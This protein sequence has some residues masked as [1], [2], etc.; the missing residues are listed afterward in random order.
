[1]IMRITTALLACGLLWACQ[2]EPDTLRIVGQ[3][4]SDRIELTAESSEPI[5]VRRVIEGQLVMVGEPLVEQNTDRALAR[6]A[7]AEALLDQAQARLDEL[8]RGPRKEQILAAQAS[9]DGSVLELEYRLV[10]LDR[11]EALLSKALASAENRDSARSA[12]DSAA[13]RLEVNKARLQELLTGTTVEELEQARAVVGQSQARLR[14][15]QI[16][17]ERS[18]TVAPVAGVVDS[19]L[20]EAGER[21]VPG[22]PIAIMLSGTTTLRPGLYSRGCPGRSCAWRQDQGLCR[23]PGRTHR[24]TGSLGFERGV[25]HTLFR[26][27]RT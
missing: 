6:V 5:V 21:P 2:Q 26:A 19:L 7:E 1:M 25:L 8:L 11:A 16:D 17:L 12:V 23:R 4:A 10:E 27:D 24:G 3:L 14:Q 20:L 22:Q 18:T 15:L 9:L 13:A